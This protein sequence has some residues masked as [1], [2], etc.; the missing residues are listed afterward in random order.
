MIIQA[1]SN[2]TRRRRKS[3]AIRLLRR[4]NYRV[5][6]SIPSEDFFEE[7]T[8]DDMVVIK[9]HSFEI[10]VRTE[11]AAAVTLAIDTSTTEVFYFQVV[12]E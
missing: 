3:L 1:E 9:R 6:E 10:V 2:S 11:Y 8:G 5:I 12:K 7:D 4:Y